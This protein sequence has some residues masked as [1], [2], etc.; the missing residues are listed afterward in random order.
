MQR[1]ECSNKKNEENKSGLEFNFLSKSK[2]AILNFDFW[3]L[4]EPYWAYHEHILGI[5]QEYFGHILSISW[6]YLDHIFGICLGHIF[7]VSWAH[8]IASPSVS[9]VSM[10]GMLGFLLGSSRGD[11]LWRI[12]ETN[13]TTLWRVVAALACSVSFRSSSSGPICPTRAGRGCLS[14]S[15][16]NCLRIKRS[17]FD[18]Y[19]R[20]QVIL[21]GGGWPSASLEVDQQFS[22]MGWQGGRQAKD[23]VRFILLGSPSHMLIEVSSQAGTLV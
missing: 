21:P 3:F 22:E 9:S 23:K 6:A 12:L 16:T 13:S 14:K 4:T 17:R 18:F 10:F 11:K 7:G 8:L 15:T 2:C 19:Q 5:F 1:K 20:R